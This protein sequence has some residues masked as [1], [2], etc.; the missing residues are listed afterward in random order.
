MGC[1][2]W[3]F[4]S[5]STSTCTTFPLGRLHFKGSD[6]GVL[7]TPSVSD[8]CNSFD[9]VCVSVCLCVCLSVCEHSHDRTD[10][11]TDLIFGV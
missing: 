7:I 2:L 10:K 5:M 3:L 11:H 4:L 1:G 9:I 6:P 8:G